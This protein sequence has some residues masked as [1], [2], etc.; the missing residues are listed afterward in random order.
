MKVRNLKV[1]RG[2]LAELCSTTLQGTGQA[3]LTSIYI[4]ISVVLRLGNLI[5]REAFL[6][7]EERRMCLL[8]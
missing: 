1:V 4:K 7:G 6:L 2:G 5:Q 8:I 3:P